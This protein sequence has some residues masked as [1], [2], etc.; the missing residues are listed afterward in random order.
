ME[1]KSLT[2]SI[3]CV[4]AGSG[5]LRMLREY[6][7]FSS[8]RLGVPFIAPRQL[9]AVGDQL[10]RHFLPS[11]EWCTGQSV[12]PPD[13]YCSGPVRNLLPYRVRPT[14]G[15]RDRLTHRTLS[16]AHRTVRCAQPTVVVGHASPADCAADRWPRAP[17]AHRTVRWIR[18]TSP[19]SFLESSQLT[20]DQPRAPDTIRCTTRQ[21]GVPGLSWCWL[22]FAIFSPIQ[23]FFSRHC[24]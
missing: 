7:V 16:G 1:L 14:V 4:E 6:L 8:M 23:I 13:S 21:S 12:A 5:S 17:L 2:Q 11:V 15:P 18:A 22:N 20:F 9:W 19:L 3:K 10:G 24:F